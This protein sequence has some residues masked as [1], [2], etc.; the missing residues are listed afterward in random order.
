[1]DN[2]QKYNAFRVA[3][4]S[5]DG[6]EIDTHFGRATE[7]YVYQHFID[8]WIFIEKRTV[9]PVCNSGK[10]SIDAMHQNVEHFADCKYVAASKIGQGA[11]TALQSKGITAMSLPRDVNEALQKIYSYNE[12]QNLFN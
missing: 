4:A 5:T 10:H 9:K 6:Y 3:V 7:F 12:I 1:M 8:E 2:E 11:M